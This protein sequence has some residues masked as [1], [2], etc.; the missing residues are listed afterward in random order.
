MLSYVNLCGV[1]LPFL[2][3]GSHM[4]NQRNKAGRTPLHHATENGHTSVIEVFLSHGADINLLTVEGQS[5]LHLA[6]ELCNKTGN[7]VEMTTSS[8]KVND[9]Y[10]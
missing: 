3:Q 9:V 6:A 5:C 10:V 2:H 1:Y 7:K 8:S 4:I